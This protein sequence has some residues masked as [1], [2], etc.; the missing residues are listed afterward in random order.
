M[1]FGTSTVSDGFAEWRRRTLDQMEN[2]DKRTVELLSTIANQMA[3]LNRALLQMQQP[4][5][6]NLATW[7]TLEEA[8]ALKGGIEYTNLRKRKW[9]MPCC[10]TN[11]KYFGGK[12][13]WNRDQVLEWCQITDDKLDDYAAKYGVDLTKWSKEKEK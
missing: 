3:E 13:V 10:G 11:F 4:P 2:D 12:R 5:P 7:Y 8:C 1:D 9:L 6:A